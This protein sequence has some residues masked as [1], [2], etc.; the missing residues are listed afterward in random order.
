MT[1]SGSKYFKLKIDTQTGKVIKKVDEDG[2]D[3]TEITSAELEQL[4]QSQAGVKHIATILYTHSSPGCIIV[5]I[6]GKIFKICF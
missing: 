3:A 6:G 1:K 4:Y 5:H 2:N